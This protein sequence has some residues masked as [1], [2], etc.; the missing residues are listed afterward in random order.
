MA[1]VKEKKNIK[2]EMGGSAWKVRLIA[3]VLLIGAVGIG[4][5][6]YDSEVKPESRFPFKL[7]LDLAGGTHLTYRADVSGLPESDIAGS[8]AALRDV[9]ERRVNIFG[10]SEPIVQVEKNSILA[11]GKREER[12]IVEL[13]GVTDISE[14]VRLIGETP[15]LEF[16]LLRADVELPED[17]T[18]PLDY[19]EYFTATEL[20]GRYLKRAQLEF[21]STQ[22]GELVNEPIVILEF[23][24]EGGELFAAITRE[25]VG[26]FLAIF[27]DGEPISIPV[28]REEITGGRATLSGNFEAEEARNLVRNLNFGALPVPIDLVGTQSIGA[29]LGADALLRGINA[30]VWGLVLVAV[31]LVLWYRLPGFLAVISLCLYLVMMLALF[32]LIPVTLTAAGLAGFILSIGM[33]V[34][35]NVLIFERM[36]EE[37]KERNRTKAAVL[38]GFARAWASIRDGNFSSILTAIVLFWFGTS[39]I[40]GFALV[41]GIGILVSMFTA[42]S[43]SRTFL[44]TLGDLENRGMRKFLFGSGLK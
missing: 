37:L 21:G 30:G 3:L 1:S 22:Q 9:I 15:L 39:L 28:I 29:S 33:A 24:T 8:M 11:E 27:L 31:F 40:K 5:F 14:A 20:T 34:D 32:K 6:V 41:F 38:E 19:G 44:L 18:E 13:P 16:K 23:N 2:K 7:G 42:I 12:L 25:H 17:E 36:R 43:I 35:A 4:Y 26:E 10:V